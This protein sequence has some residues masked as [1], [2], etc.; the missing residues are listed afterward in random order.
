MDQCGLET[1]SY[2]MSAC[3][4]NGKHDLMHDC[5]ER[6]GGGQC[7]AKDVEDGSSWE[8][9]NILAKQNT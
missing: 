3:C 4:G 2:E 9:G 5:C 1:H 8:D 6:K 7:W